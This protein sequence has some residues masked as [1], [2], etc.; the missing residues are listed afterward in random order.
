MEAHR[1]LLGALGVIASL[2]FVGVEIRQNTAAVRSATIMDTSNQVMTLLLTLATD[3]DLTRIYAELNA[4]NLGLD[5]LDPQDAIRF[6]MFVVAG[7]RRV[8]NVFLQVDQGVLNP[9][10][11]GQVGMS[12]YQLR[13]AREVWALIRLDV[14]EEF[15]TYWDE[16][17]GPE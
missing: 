15:T 7:L 14:A 13:A 5:S 2:I 16:A 4:E 8:E 9:T 6:S 10:A 3:D 1:R 12:F 17:L 11:L